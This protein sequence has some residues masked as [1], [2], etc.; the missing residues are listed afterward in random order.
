[1]GNQVIVATENGKLFVLGTDRNS[2]SKRQIASFENVV[3]NSPLSANDDIVNINGS[4]NQLYRVNIATGQKFT[5]IPL[6]SQ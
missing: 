1:M 6:T 3:I 4:D 2:P 5:P